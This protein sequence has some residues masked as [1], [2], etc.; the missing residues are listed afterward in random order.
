MLNGMG[1]ETGVDIEKLIDVAAY[2]ATF[3]GRPLQSNV[4]RALQSKRGLPDNKPS[5]SQ[6][7]SSCV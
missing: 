1:I 4:S 2:V 7:A 3:I 5:A 6:Q